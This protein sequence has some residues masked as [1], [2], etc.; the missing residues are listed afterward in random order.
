MEPEIYAATISDINNF[1][2]H[3]KNDEPKITNKPHNTTQCQKKINVEEIEDDSGV[4]AFG[5]KIISE[6]ISLGASD[7]HIEPYKTS[8]RIRYRIDGIL[9]SID[10]DTKYLNQNYPR[11]VA[12]IKMLS[13]LDIAE[14]R[15]PHDGS[16]AFKQDNRQYDLILSLIHI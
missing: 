15:K 9:K 8:S 3:I 11:V 10:Q 4:I 1:I 16:H 7:I 5:N 6:A 2:N 13:N 14:K 12:R